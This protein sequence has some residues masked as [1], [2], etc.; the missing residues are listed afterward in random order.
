M[1]DFEKISLAISIVA[2]IISVLSIV[3]ARKTQSAFLE[4]EK[5]HVELSKKQ[6]QEYDEIEINKNKTNLNVNI[7][8][9]SIFICNIGNTVASEITL[10]FTNPKDDCIIES[11]KDKLPYPML[12]PSEEFKLIG[13]YHTHEA[14]QLVSIKVKWKNMNG[15]YSEYNGVLQ[16]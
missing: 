13:S 4:F 1:S 12:N 6:L 10:D 9:G 16:P 7:Y 11:E 15:S 14:P 5:I 3:R 2:L 8:D